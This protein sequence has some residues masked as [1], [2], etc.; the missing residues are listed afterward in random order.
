MIELCKVSLWQWENIERNKKYEKRTAAQNV[1]SFS[2]DDAT[3]MVH[4][5]IEKHIIIFFSY[6][7]LSA[8]TSIFFH[9]RLRS[10]PLSVSL[11]LSSSLSLILLHIFL[12]LYNYSAVECYHQPRA[13]NCRK[14]ESI[15]KEI[16]IF[17]FTNSELETND[18]H[19]RSCRNN[20]KRLISFDFF[21]FVCVYV[22]VNSN[23]FFLRL[24]S[25]V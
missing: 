17:F 24:S 16:K 8:L 14:W 9:W 10:L 15:N 12:A 13:L 18:G 11:S 2:M 3:T 23:E 1:F 20:P 22:C 21:S 25:L 4:I 6:F 19:H 5:I 7:L